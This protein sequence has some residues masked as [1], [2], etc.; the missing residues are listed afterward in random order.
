MW[1]TS[2]TLTWTLALIGSNK[3]PKV[4]LDTRHTCW[5][6]H[7]QSIY[8]INIY[9]S[10]D[11]YCLSRYVLSSLLGASC[12]RVTTEA[13]TT[14]RCT[15]NGPPRHNIIPWSQFGLADDRYSKSSTNNWLSCTVHHK[16]LP[17]VLASPVL[18]LLL[19]W[20]AYN[21]LA[22]HYP[23]WRTQRLFHGD[24]SPWINILSNWFPCLRHFS[25][26]L[27]VWTTTVSGLLCCCIVTVTLCAQYI[28]WWRIHDQ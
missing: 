10:K 24:Q 1:L 15:L 16:T 22:G 9:D 4:A 26:H 19:K 20:K 18:I 7:I 21:S 27:A 8:Y 2:V 13:T 12:I 14:I 11:A 3:V 5:D 17:L 23:C 6:Q 28:L 25:T